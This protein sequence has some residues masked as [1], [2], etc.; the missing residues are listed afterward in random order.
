[1]LL[2]LA[3]DS[4]CQTRNIQDLLPPEEEAAPWTRA[5]EPLKYQADNLYNFINGGAEVYLEYGFVQVV[6]QE[7]VRA[8]S[9]V[10]CTIYEMKD[11]QAAFGIF[12]YNRSPQKPSIPVGDGGFKGGLQTA[13]WQDR[14]FV[15]VESFSP[16]EE[17]EPV[18]VSLARQISRSIGDHAEEPEVIRR[19]PRQNLIE[20]STKLLKGR[21]AVDSLFFLEAADLFQLGKGDL[22]LSGEYQST[23]GKTKLFL[24]VYRQGEKAGRT[25]LRLYEAFSPDMGYRFVDEQESQSFWKKGERY[26]A[27]GQQADTLSLITEAA[28][29]EEAREIMRQSSMPY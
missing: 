7:Y 26:I 4:G 25:Y 3:L 28:S 6:S 23:H 22:V 10:I 8:E 27:L 29:L 21:L 11:P 9:S 18:L 5:D 13:F 14:Y 24:V 19:L 2:V 1:M 15:L 16:G 12:S 20:S 17:A